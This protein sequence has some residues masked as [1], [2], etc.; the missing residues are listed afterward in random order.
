LTPANNDYALSQNIKRDNFCAMKTALLVPH[1]VAARNFLLGKFA[2]KL[3]THGPVFVIHPLG[4]SLREVVSD[5]ANDIE[6]I[7]SPPFS[8]GILGYLI[9]R[10]VLLGHMH[11]CNTV[12]M[13]RMLQQYHRKLKGRLTVERLAGHLTWWL[14]KAATNHEQLHQWSEKYMKLQSM[15][16]PNLAYVEIFQETRPDVIFCTDQ[17]PPEMAAVVAAARTYRIPVGTFI[18]SWDNLSSKGRMP[19]EFDFYCV[20]SEL[21]KKELLQFYP[22]IDPDTVYITGTPQFEPYFDEALFMSRED[23]CKDVKAD[24]NRPMICYAGEDIVT[25]PENPEHLQVICD[26]LKDKRIIGNPQ[27]LV[28]PAPA[29]DGSRWDNVRT[30]NPDIIWS[31]PRWARK[32]GEPWNKAIPTIDD[33][34]LLTN[35]IRHSECCVN[36]V[37]TMTL[38]FA[39]GGKPSVNIAFDINDPPPHGMP[40]WD[41]LFQFEHY[42]P[43]VELRASL[44]AHSSDELAEKI[45]L[46]I[47]EGDINR[48]SREAFIRLETD[49]HV[50]SAS[51][52]IACVLES[53]AKK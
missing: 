25:D 21:M 14:S 31:M 8:E 5:I 19:C 30:R 13:K 18:F 9:R 41:M 42:R 53:V 46:S 47:R 49:G 26:L 34:R 45:N 16:K 39:I 28:R 20:W 15:R 22:Y 48:A 35:T 38:D 50:T 11:V 4:P 36:M 17:R 29:D 52:N 3:L 6:W 27:I 40:V 7:E 44:I 1:G 37:S 23:F 12:G 24:H 2:S 51:E 43:V 33:I 10:T 32:N